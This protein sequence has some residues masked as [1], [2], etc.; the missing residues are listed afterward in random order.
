MQW[1][2]ELREWG[3]WAIAI[4]AL[5]VAFKNRSDLNRDAVE[6]ARQ[7]ILTEHLPRAELVD[8]PRFRGALGACP[9]GTV[10]HVAG[11]CIP[12]DAPA[13]LNLAY[14]HAKLNRL[15]VREI[16][17]LAELAD[18]LESPGYVGKHLK[19]TAYLERKAV[20]RLTSRRLQR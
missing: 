16:R 6:H 5:L 8:P 15:P 20:G 11:K 2:T 9:S 3:S 7:K 19:T 4:V 12:A 14:K 10:P 13:E 1:W 18:S 17:K